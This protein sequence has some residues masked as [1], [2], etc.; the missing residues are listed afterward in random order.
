M[1]LVKMRSLGQS[2]MS[3]SISIRLD[4]SLLKSSIESPNSPL[5]FGQKY[6]KY[7]QGSDAFL[8][9]DAVCKS[10]L[11]ELIRNWRIGTELA[12]NRPFTLINL[13]MVV[14]TGQRLKCFR[15]GLATSAKRRLVT[16]AWPQFASAIPQTIWLNNYLKQRQVI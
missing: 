5:T 3:S 2:Q 9:A 10:G 15:A 13:V 14:E 6:T 12:S 11:Y 1:S 7:F 8:N 4:W 16:V